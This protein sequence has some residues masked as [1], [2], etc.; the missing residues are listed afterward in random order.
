MKVKNNHAPKPKKPSKS[1]TVS[2]MINRRNR[3]LDKEQVRQLLKDASKPV[4]AKP[5]GMENK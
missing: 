2:Q 3:R 1:A 5:I 4:T